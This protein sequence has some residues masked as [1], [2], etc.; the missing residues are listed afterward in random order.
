MEGIRGDSVNIGNN[1]YKNSIAKT[2]QSPENRGQNDHL[3]KVIKNDKFLLTY[4]LYFDKISTRIVVD[5]ST[6]PHADRQGG[7]RKA[8]DRRGGNRNP[9]PCE[10]DG[11]EAIG[12]VGRVGTPAKD[13]GK[14]AGGTDST[15]EAG[16]PEMITG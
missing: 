1:P 9:A 16:T 3:K 12:Q 7:G 8:N 4:S 5:Y 14:T 11:G 2:P 13:T 6:P 10:R 15:R